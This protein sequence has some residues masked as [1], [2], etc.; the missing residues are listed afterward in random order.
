VELDLGDLKLQAEKESELELDEQVENL[1]GWIHLH[2]LES[3]G[4][5]AM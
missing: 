2:T 4:R 1:A 3:G 5:G